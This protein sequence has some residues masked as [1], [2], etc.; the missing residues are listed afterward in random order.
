[1]QSK[2][3]GYVPTRNF[4]V[5]MIVL[6]L[7]TIVAMLYSASAHAQEAFRVAV[8]NPAGT[9]G[10]MAKDLFS[11]C[12][13]AATGLNVELVATS[14]SIENIALL[15]GNKVNAA[16][17]Q[18][19][20]LFATKE[21]DPGKVS[22]IKSLFGLHPEELHFVA[23]ADVKKEGGWLGGRIG[24]TSVTFTKLDDLTGRPL[25][26][27]GGSVFSGRVVSQYGRLRLQVVDAG[28]N[29]ALLKQLLEAKID[30]A[31]MVGGQPLTIVEKLDTRY[32]LL[33]VPP[34]LQRQLKEVYAPAKLSYSNLNQSGIDS[35][36]TQAL[37]VTREYSSPAML[38]NLAKLRACFEAK[39]PDIKDANGTHAKWQ[40]VSLDAPG[41]WPRYALPAAK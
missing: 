41:T 33:P 11:R 23:R 37:M 17:V 21:S 12:D 28:N 34:E 13:A 9:Y 27:V 3:Q 20:I 24:G 1:M 5:S 22:R 36:A 32:R 4:L 38:N 6:L 19:D 40:E 25:G 7:L 26:A 35:L 18:S 16:F 29:D 10:T 39:L 31:L 30:S 2:T 15:S 14:G 8:G